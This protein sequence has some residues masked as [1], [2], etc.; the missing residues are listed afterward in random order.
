MLVGVHFYCEIKYIKACRIFL[1]VYL[2]IPFCKIP[3]NVAESFSIV[4]KFS[5]NQSIFT[6]FNFKEFYE[7]FLV[8]GTSVREHSLVVKFSSNIPMENSIVRI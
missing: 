1:E 4:E 8:A 3:H 7:C 6:L 2:V 5:I